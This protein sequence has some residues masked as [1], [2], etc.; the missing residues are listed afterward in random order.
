MTLPLARPGGPQ[1]GGQPPVA[2]AAMA[3]LAGAAV[4]AGARVASQ[5]P[6]L[7]AAAALRSA[8]E[9]HCHAASPQ[10]EGEG[11]ALEDARRARQ[12]PQ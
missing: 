4:G 9:P 3:A 11:D 8:Q 1:G 6:Q 12:Q 5:K 10:A 2:D 7:A